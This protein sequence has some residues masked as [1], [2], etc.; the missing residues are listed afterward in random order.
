M[1]YHSA[2]QKNSCAILNCHKCQTKITEVQ[3]CVECDKCHNY[4]HLRCEGVIGQ[5][6][7]RS[8]EEWYCKE[9]KTT[10]SSETTKRT[11][12]D[13]SPDSNIDNPNKRQNLLE[14]P[15]NKNDKMLDKIFNC[16]IDLTCSH[17]DIKNLVNDVKDN[18][19]F[20]S[21]QFDR[22]D[23]KLENIEKEQSRMKKDLLST[24]KIQNE[25]SNTIYNLE[26]EVDSYKQKELEN[27]IIIGGL[28][29]N[30]DE[31]TIIQNI[32]STLK[33][34]CTINDVKEVLKLN[35]KQNIQNTNAS[36]T[37]N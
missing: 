18:Q 16:L 10:M 32:M 22:I 20:L 15:T 35:G 28:S 17:N 33:T 7:A 14:T 21:S 19:A 29:K 13:T 3:H 24:Q 5:H 30:F 4:F 23:K 36:E 26:A 6:I 2:D 12:A 25:H 34:T 1:P 27:N 37:N 11:I 8:V 9:C 31:N